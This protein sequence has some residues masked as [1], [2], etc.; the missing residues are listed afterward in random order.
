MNALILLVAPV[1][2]STAIGYTISN[3]EFG[4]FLLICFGIIY[5]ICLFGSIILNRIL[6]VTDN[7]CHETPYFLP[8]SNIACFFCRIIQF[9][10]PSTYN[11]FKKINKEK[12]EKREA[13]KQE[14]MLQKIKER[15]KGLT[16]I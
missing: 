14:S 5:L 1:Q 4:M 8:I 11:G 9:F 3:E 13:K 16:D 2:D 12:R 6:K 10:K 15:T 7:Y